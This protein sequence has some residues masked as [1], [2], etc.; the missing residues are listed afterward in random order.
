MAGLGAAW[1]L[2]RAG[3]QVQVIERSAQLGGRVRSSAGAQAA[4]AGW[5]GSRDRQ[6]SDWLAELSQDGEAR[7]ASIPFAAYSRN[8]RLEPLAGFAW[9]ALLGA[10]G[11]R[12][13]Q[14]L[15]VS[16]LGRL[17]RR[18]GDN[19]DPDAPECAAAQDDRS[20][21]DFVRL[22]FGP[23]VLQSWVVP[24]LT[25]WDVYDP[26]N[27]SR[28]VLLRR[29]LRAGAAPVELASGWDPIFAALQEKL[30][31]RTG[32]G[33]SGI[34][35]DA[36]GR[37]KVSLED[38]ATLEADAVVVATPAPR[39]L[40]L[41]ES[42]ATPAERDFLGTVPYARSLV[43]HGRGSGKALPAVRVCV[44]DRDGAFSIVR[45]ASGGS[46]L[47]AAGP[48][49]EANW[50]APDD[51]VAKA[52]LARP[53]PPWRDPEDGVELER[54]D[55]GIPQF[56]VGQFRALAR[57]RAVQCDRRSTGRAL[58]FAGDY[59]AEASLEGALASGFR[60]AADLLSDARA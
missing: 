43:L 11:I 37:W 31:V 7:E 34:E 10:Y 38:G 13:H 45:N 35:V 19:L 2:S 24:T 12:A 23:S 58:Y 56:G 30:D 48:W 49:V 32:A 28:V 17:L 21:A 55:P 4:V 5:F 29:A 53:A 15:R 1:R 39:A 26:E 50:D 57:F 54:I 25:A 36:A 42:V 60:A 59:L 8:G 14:A 51:V 52:W 44:A 6:V 3:G 18:F 33:A 16:R 41:L 47:L 22:Y 46:A 27:A 9:R 40:S 20:V